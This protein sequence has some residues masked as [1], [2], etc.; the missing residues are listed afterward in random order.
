MVFNGKQVHLEE[1]CDLIKFRIV[2]WVTAHFSG[3]F[4]YVHEI[5]NN[6]Q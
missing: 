5:V 2:V 3:Y 1:V 4:Y 6:I